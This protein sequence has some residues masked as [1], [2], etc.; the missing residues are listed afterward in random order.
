MKKAAAKAGRL[1]R[2]SLYPMSPE[3]ALRQ[4]MSVPPL[5][6]ETN[7]RDMKTRSKRRKLRHLKKK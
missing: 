2:L 4:A 6:G 1:E 7:G 5:N 3:E